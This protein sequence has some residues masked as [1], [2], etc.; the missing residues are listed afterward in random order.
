[1]GLCLDA[2]PPYIPDDAVRLVVCDKTNEELYDILSDH[3]MYC[4]EDSWERNV[5]LELLE[6]EDRAKYYTKYLLQSHQENSME[7]LELLTIL[8][9]DGREVRVYGISEEVERQLMEEDMKA[10]KTQDVDEDWDRDSNYPVFISI[11][12]SL[13]SKLG[14]VDVKVVFIND[15]LYI[16]TMEREQYANY[17]P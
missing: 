3:F 2:I 9:V 5:D 4:E 10:S 16:K 15:H 17:I 14:S 7:K 1:M 12:D 6:Y 11:K 8:F 13:Q